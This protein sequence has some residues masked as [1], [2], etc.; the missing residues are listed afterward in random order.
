VSATAKDGGV[1]Y[2][3]RTTEGG[4]PFVEWVPGSIDISADEAL[5][6]SPPEETSA[7]RDCAHWLS[8]LL[9]TGPKPAK[10]VLAEAEQYGFTS[11]VVRRARERLEVQT[12]KTDFK[13][14]WV[15]ESK[16]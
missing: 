9:A 10:A 11:K 13:D 12:R 6:G 8:E 15:W 14:G 7:T 5:A 4:V 1:S 16:G 2:R 3:M